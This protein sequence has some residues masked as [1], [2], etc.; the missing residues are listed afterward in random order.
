MNFVKALTGLAITVTLIVLFCCS[1]SSR[2][3]DGNSIGIIRIGTQLWMSENLDVSHFLNGDEITEAR[4]P[5][6]WVRMGI[7]KKPAWCYGVNNPDNSNGYGRL[8][9][10]Y[11]VN[12]PRGLAPKGWHIASD[13]EWTQFIDFMGNEVLAAMF[14]RGSGLSEEGN[15]PINTGIKFPPAGARNSNGGYLN[16]GSHGYWWSG[17]EVNGSDAWCRLLNYVQCNIYSLDFSKTA[18]LS[19]RCIKD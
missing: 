6:G 16:P 11:A 12:D 3:Q 10:W 18:G 13:E 7:E 4:S 17:T 5:E 1:G 9:N 15:K 14:M 8:Y 2:D 19:V